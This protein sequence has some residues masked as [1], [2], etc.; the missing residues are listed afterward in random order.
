MHFDIAI[1][2]LRTNQ[3]ALSTVA[4]NLANANTDGYHRRR[5]TLAARDPQRIQNLFLGAGVE[6]G[7]I[8]RW[9]NQLLESSY[10]NSI[11]DLQ[12]IEQ[13]LTLERR[14]EDLFLPG[15]G[16]LQESLT[17]YFNELSALSA[18][19][20]EIVQR[21]S[22]VQTAVTLGQKFNNASSQLTDIKTAIHAQ[23]RLEVNELNRE[24]EELANLQREI[25]LNQ[26]HSTPNDLLDRRDQLI[27]RIAEKIDVQRNENVNE[28]QGLSIAGHSISLGRTPVVFEAYI[29]EVGE[30]GYRFAGSDGEVEFAGGRLAGLQ[31]AYNETI[32]DY[33]DR[34]DQLAGGLIRNINQVH[35]QGIGANG[36]FVSLTGQYEAS[37]PNLPLA[38]AGL[39]FPVEAGELFLSVVDGDG[40]RQTVSISIDPEVDTLNDI[41]ARLNALDGIRSSVNGFNGALLIGAEPGLRFDFTGNLES[42]PDLAS[43]SGSSQPRVSGRYQGRDNQ[44]MRVEIVGT[45]TIGVTDGLLARVYDGSGAVVNEVSIGSD[46]AA[47]SEIE[48]YEGVSLSFGAGDVTAGDEFTTELVKDS[49]RGGFLSALGFN[50]FFEGDSAFS[51]A[52]REGLIED[53]N[54]LASSKTG[55]DGDTFNLIGM[56]GIRDTPLV[57]GETLDDFLADVVADIGLQVRSTNSVRQSLTELKDGYK[58]EIDA[59]SGV[60]VNEELLDMTK[61]QQAYEASVQVIRTMEAMMDE[62]FQILR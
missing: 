33:Q 26:V 55:E 2:G 25:Q 7:G 44:D 14:V 1:S 56:V 19:P 48:V 3:F 4:H 23:V 11:S 5:I 31:H 10:T 24:I 40:E 22:V 28:G 16:S 58:S 8:G 12:S 43:F 62:L 54:Q 50:S 20:G 46:Y 39:P 9:R 35:A 34:L 27:N 49:D 21:N 57:E 38:D 52:V 15:E 53:P 60:D 17:D 30:I 47:G 36:S 18:N 13:Q 61:Y 29:D 32:T 37:D 51:M 6:V 59:F 41:S 45:G 42:V